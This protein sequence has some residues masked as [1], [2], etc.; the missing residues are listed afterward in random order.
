MKSE[1]DSSSAK[2]CDICGRMFFK[3]PC[4][5]CGLRTGMERADRLRRSVPSVVILFNMPL[6]IHSDNSR[7]AA[8]QVEPNRLSR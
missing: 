3:N 7:F 6:A 4:L 8:D 2:I 5:R 1:L